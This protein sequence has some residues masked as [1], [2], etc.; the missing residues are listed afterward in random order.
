MTNIAEK[1]HDIHQRIQDSSS[2]AGRNSNDIQLLAVSKTQT[3]SR[4]LEAYNTGQRAFGENYLQEARDKQQV[5]DDLDIEWHFIGPI[6]S[7]KTREIATH[8]SWVHSVD[9]L[10]IAERLSKQRPAGLPLLNICIQVNI[11][12]ESTKAGATLEELASL[13]NA[14]NILPNLALRGLMAIP[15]KRDDMEAQQQVFERVAKTMQRL[16]LSNPT[17][18]LDTLS[19][20]MSDDMDAAIASGATIIRVGSAIFGPRK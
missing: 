6:Q 11:D 3:P 2:R 8:F 18:Q 15:A 4:I 10:K 9:R 14:I 1:I 13:A 20:G 7:N 12:N 16:T 5:L 17:L 19:M